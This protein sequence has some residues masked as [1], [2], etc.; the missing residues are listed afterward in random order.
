MRFNPAFKGLKS[1]SAPFVLRFKESKMTDPEDEGTR[2]LR[3][4]GSDTASR[5]SQKT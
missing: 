4:V 1:G 3:N 2:I 5:A